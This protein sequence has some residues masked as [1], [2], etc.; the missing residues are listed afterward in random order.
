MQEVTLFIPRVLTSV[1]RK[2]ITEYFLKEKI[3]Y[4]SHIKSKYRINTK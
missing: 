1:S 2:N 4:C 3:G